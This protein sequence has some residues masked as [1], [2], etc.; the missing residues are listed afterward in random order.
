MRMA[1]EIFGRLAVAVQTHRCMTKCSVFVR[2]SVM[3]GVEGFAVKDATARAF[4][5]TGK[6][7][8]NRLLIRY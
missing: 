6:R 1:E 4:M 3:K 2:A 8:S 7:C 5:Q